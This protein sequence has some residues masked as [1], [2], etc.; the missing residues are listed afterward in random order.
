[1][2][3]WIDDFFSKEIFPPFPSDFKIENETG[4]SDEIWYKIISFVKKDDETNYS[5]NYAS[6]QLIK[7]YI[8]RLK[9]LNKVKN[10]NNKLLSL[11]VNKILSN[12]RRYDNMFSELRLG[13]LVQQVGYSLNEISDEKISCVEYNINIDKKGYYHPV[14]KI[15]L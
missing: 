14:R 13:T 10:F 11:M 2:N 12:P 15:I 3:S 4:D 8:E 1:M 7:E 6:P 5:F 9:R